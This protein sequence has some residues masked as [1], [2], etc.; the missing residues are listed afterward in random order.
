VWDPG[1]AGEGLPM[2]AAW[3]APRLSVGE[4]QPTLGTD[5]GC[6]PGE[7]RSWDRPREGGVSRCPGSCWPW[8]PLP[9]GW[10]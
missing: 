10:C 8:P 7:P 3:C 6:T 9:Q 4:A 2:P 5:P 1:L